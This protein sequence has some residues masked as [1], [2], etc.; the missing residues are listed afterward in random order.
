MGVGS[1]FALSWAS[2][3]N[4]TKLGCRSLQAPNMARCPGWRFDEFSE[5]KKGAVVALY[6]ALSVESLARAEAAQS[7]ESPGRLR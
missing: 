4:V 3:T 6:L 2:R 5:I 1:N 7:T